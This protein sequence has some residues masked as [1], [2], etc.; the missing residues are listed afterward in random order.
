MSVLYP[1]KL[2]SMEFGE[3]QRSVR[4]RGERRK[5][6]GRCWHLKLG[7]TF[8]GKAPNLVSTQLQ[9]PYSSTLIYR[10]V[11][12]AAVACRNVKCRQFAIVCN[13]P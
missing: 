7:K 6:S 12:Q 3:P 2:A 11:T 9:E 4:R 1:T 10:E 13:T 8:T 5:A